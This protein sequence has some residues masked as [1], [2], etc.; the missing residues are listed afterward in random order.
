MS[1]Y[2]TYNNMF[3]RLLHTLIL[4]IAITDFGV[5]ITVSVT[6]IMSS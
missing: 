4:H 3:L 6:H 2:V 5:A 1:G